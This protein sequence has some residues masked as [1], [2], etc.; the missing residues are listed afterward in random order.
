MQLPARPHGIDGPTWIVGIF[1]TRLPQILI[2]LA[3][4]TSTCHPRETESL[5]SRGAPRASS[6]AS[7]EGGGREQAACCKSTP[8]EGTPPAPGTMV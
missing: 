8:D 5:G 2:S 7:P 1:V 4:L 6:T 3:V